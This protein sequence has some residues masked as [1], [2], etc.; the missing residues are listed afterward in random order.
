[1]HQYKINVPVSI[2]ILYN[3]RR[4]RS[5]DTLNIDSV[6]LTLYIFHEKVSSLWRIN[7]TVH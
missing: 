6:L 7:S 1:M 4:I 3:L 5:R 2:K